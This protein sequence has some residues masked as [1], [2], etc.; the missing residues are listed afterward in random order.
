MC[1]ILVWQLQPSAGNMDCDEGKTNLLRQ[2]ET[3]LSV[4]R[5]SSCSHYQ[6][7]AALLQ[8]AN[9]SVYGS[10]WAD[11]IPAGSAQRANP[12]LSSSTCH[13][14]TPG[15]LYKNGER[16]VVFAA[17]RLHPVGSGWGTVNPRCSS[18]PV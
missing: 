12:G 8:S 1:V 13:L 3:Q 9:S 2:D 11:H 4:S 18:S 5:I 17:C 7:T 14:P 6:H 10:L 16:P 15:T